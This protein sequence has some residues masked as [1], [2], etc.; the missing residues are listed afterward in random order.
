MKILFVFAAKVIYFFY[1]YKKN[2]YF[3]KK[4]YIILKIYNFYI[5]IPFKVAEEASKIFTCTI[6]PMRVFPLGK[7]TVLY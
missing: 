7:T 1:I 5:N 4:I 6:S 2:A 3:L